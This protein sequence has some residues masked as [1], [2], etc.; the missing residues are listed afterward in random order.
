VNRIEIVL[1]FFLEIDGIDLRGRESSRSRN[2]ASGELELSLRTERGELFNLYRNRG[3][4]ITPM[5][6]IRNYFKAIRG[7]L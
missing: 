6:K 4:R 5:T 7:Q 1:S 2:V 3:G